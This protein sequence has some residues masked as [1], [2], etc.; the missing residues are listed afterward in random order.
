[1]RRITAGADIIRPRGT[2]SNQQKNVRRIRTNANS[3]HVFILCGFLP[4]QPS[5]YHRQHPDQHDQPAGDRNADRPAPEEKAVE[6]MPV[7]PVARPLKQD[8][9]DIIQKRKDY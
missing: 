3:P 9:S 6:I 1:M 8:V 5:Q 2:I 7:R 4:V